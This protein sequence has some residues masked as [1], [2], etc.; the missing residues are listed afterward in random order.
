MTRSVIFGAPKGPF[1]AAGRMFCETKA[2][3]NFLVSANS[4][5]FEQNLIHDDPSRRFF[6]ILILL[7]K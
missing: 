5:P 7:K 6:K 3:M 2:E 4:G 1:A